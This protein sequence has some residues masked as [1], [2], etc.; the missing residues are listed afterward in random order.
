MQVC[1]CETRPACHGSGEEL[2]PVV[3]ADEANLQKHAM[4]D[5]EDLQRIKWKGEGGREGGQGQRRSVQGPRSSREV[6]GGGGLT[7]CHPSFPLCPPP[8]LVCLS[9]THPGFFHTDFVLVQSPIWLGRVVSVTFSPALWETSASY[10]LPVFNH[11]FTISCGKHENPHAVSM[12][13]AGGGG[14][15]DGGRR[16]TMVRHTPGLKWH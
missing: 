2:G 9:F 14:G 12:F 7:R 5:G 16:V 13:T 8:P 3:G 10:F 11:R 15:G 1:E 4:L 6:G